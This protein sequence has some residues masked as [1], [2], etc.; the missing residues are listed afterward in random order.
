LFVGST[1]VREQAARL[2]AALQLG[3]AGPLLHALAVDRSADA[4]ARVHALQALAVLQAADLRGA[5][6]SALEDAEAEVRAAGLQILAQTAPGEAL[7]RLRDAAQRGTLVER[8]AA[9]AAL[10]TIRSPAADAV[11]ADWLEQLLGGQVAAEVQLDLLTAAA[12]RKDPAVREKL[13]AYEAARRGDDPLAQ[14]RETLY[15]GDARRGED[16]FYNR[17]AV[18]CRRCH[19]INGSGGNIGP[20][21]T[22]IGAQKTREYLLEALVAPDRT[23]AQGFESVVLTTVDGRIFVGILKGED[24]R[25]LRLQTAEGNYLTIDKDQIDDRAR[26]RSAM[27]DDLP[28]HLTKHELRDLVEFLSRLR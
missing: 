4:A 21:L 27:P 25:T 9:L 24:D 19:A 6:R 20:E 23:I 8:Q 14:F 10:G 22:R 7:P 11:L 2:A 5:L 12:Q 17:V 3:D 18:A 13:A 16:I 28:K 15:G 26:G 1:K